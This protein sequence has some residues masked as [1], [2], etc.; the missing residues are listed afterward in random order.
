MATENREHKQVRNGF[1]QSNTTAFDGHGETMKRDVRV[2]SNKKNKPWLDP[3]N[4]GEDPGMTSGDLFGDGGLQD[5][6][7][8]KLQV[9]PTSEYGFLDFPEKYNMEIVNLPLLTR[10]DVRKC[11]VLVTGGVYENL[12]FFP[13]IQLLKDRYPGV[14]IDVVA[15]ERGKQTY[16]MNKNVKRAWVYD[17]DSQFVEPSEYLEFVGKLKVS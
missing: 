16:E 6:N 13:V 11:C 12:L 10:K 15:N 5:P 17:I 14:E 1:D 7:P 9:D 8:P 4:Y 3:F 2:Y